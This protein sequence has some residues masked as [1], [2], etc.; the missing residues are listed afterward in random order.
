[1]EISITEPVRQD[2]NTSYTGFV[3]SGK[4]HSLSKPVSLSVKLGRQLY[5][6]Y[7]TPTINYIYV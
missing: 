3:I 4:W 5:P 2:S 7:A 6:V 1:M